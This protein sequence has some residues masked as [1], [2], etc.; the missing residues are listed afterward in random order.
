MRIKVCAKPLTKFTGD[1]AVFFVDEGKEYF[2]PPDKT[3]AEL[4]QHYLKAVK[5]K[6]IRQEMVVTP[7]TSAPFKAYYFYAPS[8]NKFY[9]YSEAVK[10]AANHCQEY[11]TNMG[12]ARMCF[13]LD[14][15]AGASNISQIAEGL[16]LGAYRFKKY[17]TNEKQTEVVQHICLCVAEKVLNTARKQLD[18]TAELC[19][20][21]NQCREIIN[22]PPDRIYPDSLAKIARQ[23]AARHNLRCQVLDER[24][25]QRAGYNATLKVG[26]GSQ[27]PPRLVV[28][29][30][31]PAGKLASPTDKHLCLIGKGITFDTGGICL[32]P[33]DRMWE[34][35]SDMT[36]AAVVIFVMAL[37][38]R[39]KPPFPITAIAPLVQNAIGS[40]AALPGEIIITPVGKTIHVINT[41]AEGRL[42]L[43]DAMHLAG[44]YKPTHIIDIA[45]LTGSIVRALGT[46][47]TGLFANDPQWAEQIIRAGKEVGEDMWEMPLYEEY[48]K[49]LKSE[50]ADIDNVTATP[51]GGAITAALF[52]QEFV[53]A[54]AKWAHLDIAGTAFVEKKWKYYNAGATACPLKTIYALI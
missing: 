51:N 38:A 28:I 29:E 16:L 43:T 6:K 4:S 1:L 35:K 31:R 20:T 19:T 46:S 21:I 52:L 26:R 24:Q 10:I 47:L 54:G 7:P 33:P 5:Q 34:M 23:L 8:L 2:L 42:I 12:Y 44:K 13:L 11:A 50:V 36:G 48:K 30:Y 45:T 22:E 32:K 14:S 17:K 9:S 3:I 39:L 18:N 53:P 27:Y 49:L 41:D 15:S 25:L 40:R 37:V